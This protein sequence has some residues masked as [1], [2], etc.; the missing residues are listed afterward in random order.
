MKPLKVVLTPTRNRRLNEV[1]GL[2]LL[3][4]AGLLLLSL[5]SCQP[6]DPSLNT[7]VG[8]PSGAATAQN[9]VGVVGATLS[10]LLFQV[11]GVAAFC[12]PMMLIALGLTWMRSRVV[13]SPVAKL[14][15]FLLYVL[16]APSV[17]A[18]LP[19]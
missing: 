2:V 10:D 16:F 1:V 3:V 18:L 17:F 7:V 5:V 12:L 14:V 11:D 8:G 19:G 13:G 4:A 9:W 15:G 6:T